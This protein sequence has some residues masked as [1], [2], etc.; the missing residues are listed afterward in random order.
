[1]VGADL[2]AVEQSR[3]CAGKLYYLD[4]TH[5]Y[6][7]LVMIMGGLQVTSSSS[8]III[9]ALDLGRTIWEIVPPDRF[10]ISQAPVRELTTT[11]FSRTRPLSG[12]I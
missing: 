6:T 9:I 3:D 5:L 10:A 8:R 1:M 7:L 2:R 4:S 11:T 12:S